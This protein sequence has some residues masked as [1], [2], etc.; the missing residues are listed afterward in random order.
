MGMLTLEMLKKHTEGTVRLDLLSEREGIDVSL[1][2]RWLG[3][4]EYLGLNPSSPPGSETWIDHKA[5]DALPMAEREL[6]RTRANRE[7]AERAER[8]FESLPPDVRE[9][10]ETQARDVLY[11]VVALAALEPR[12]TLDQ[13]RQL[14][15]DAEV[16]AVSILRASG[17]LKPAPVR[18]EPPPV[19]EEE[20]EAVAA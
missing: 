14:G 6:A 2:Y 9:R 16:A 20:P 11:G 13:A 15:P 1:R 5:I 17:I 7:F 8:W 19:V 4:E 18:A 12:L 10:R 3:R